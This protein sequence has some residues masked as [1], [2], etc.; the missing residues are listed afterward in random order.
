MY[1]TT[2]ARKVK[3]ASGGQRTGD[4]VRGFCEYVINVS[5]STGWKQRVAANEPDDIEVYFTRGNTD[6]K[7]DAELGSD[8]LEVSRERDTQP[9]ADGTYQVGDAAEVRFTSDGSSLSLDNVSTKDGWSVTK[10][11]VSTDDIEIDFRKGKATAEFGAEISNGQTKLEIN[12]KA[13][14]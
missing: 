14:E 4:E 6:W 11:E 10:R 5:P 3:G 7:F 1:I 2:H 13:I 8:G 9:A 12:Q